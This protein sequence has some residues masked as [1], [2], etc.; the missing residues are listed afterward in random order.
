MYNVM[1]N[2]CVPLFFAR[3]LLLYSAVSQIDFQNLLIE[4]KSG[5]SLN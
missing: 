1:S 5:G 3:L 2:S 4:R